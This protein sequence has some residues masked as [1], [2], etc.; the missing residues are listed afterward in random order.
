MRL[1]ICE[2][3]WLFASVL[4]A[5]FEQQGHEVVA[6]SDDPQRLFDATGGTHPDLYVLDTP[7][8]TRLPAR[9]APAPYVLLLADAQDDRAWAAFDNGT[10]DGVVSKTCGLRTLIEVAESVANG[11]HV[12]EGRP[13]ADR[14]RSRPV[15]DA[16]T[17]RELEVLRL[18]VRGYNTEQMAAV[19]GVSRHTIRTHVQQ[20]L[21]KLGVHGRGKLARAAADAGLVDVRELVEDGRR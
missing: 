6:T 19:L 5:A 14:R 10:A 20:V 2:E 12:A 15:V 13:A 1:A 21:R 16:L 18:V 8:A 11:N 9:Q 17:A 4:A 3:H 7:A